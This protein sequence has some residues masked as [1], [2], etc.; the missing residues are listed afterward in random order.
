MSHAIQWILCVLF[1]EKEEMRRIVLQFKK[2]I[3]HQKVLVLP[4]THSGK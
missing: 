4:E 3:G 2:F 1:T